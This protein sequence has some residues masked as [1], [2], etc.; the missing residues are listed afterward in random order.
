MGLFQA[1]TEWRE[2]NYKKKIDKSRIQG[3]CPDCSGNGYYHWALNEFAIA[4]AELLSCQ[5][6]DGS[7]LFS[8]W[9]ANR[10]PQ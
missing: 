8:D 10:L 1:I 3:K 4:S 6:C 7:G 5:G 2:E 9:E